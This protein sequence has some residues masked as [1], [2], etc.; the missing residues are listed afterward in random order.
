MT[1]LKN[2]VLSKC[3]HLS[4][5]FSRVN[6][7]IK[8][9]IAVTV[10]HA[11]TNPRK[12]RMKVTVRLWICVTRKL[13]LNLENYRS[14]KNILIIK[15]SNIF[16]F[17]SSTKTFSFLCRSQTQIFK[18]NKNSLLEFAQSI[19]PKKKHNKK[20]SRK[21]NEI[22]FARKKKKIEYLHEWKKVFWRV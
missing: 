16:N 13:W 7:K 14:K 9:C 10:N 22:I 15:F 20:N 12:R 19:N 1:S 3:Y 21:K 17:L 4:R 2:R 11:Q 6:N 18:N 5:E 8:I